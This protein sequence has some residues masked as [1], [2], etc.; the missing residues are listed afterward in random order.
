MKKIVL[1]IMMMFVSLDFVLA[2]ENV[3]IDVL[4]VSTDTV[5]LEVKVS[6]N[7]DDV[8]YLYKSID[9]VNFDDQIVIDCNTMYVDKN[10]EPGIKY[11]YKASYGNDIEYSEV[12]EVFVEKEEFKTISLKRDIKEISIGGKGFMIS[13]G[14]SLLLLLSCLFLVKNKLN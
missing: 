12:I 9:G 4:S 11:Y 6:K 7:L 5:T 8:C 1:V 13:F 10:I 2:K 3:R 14:L